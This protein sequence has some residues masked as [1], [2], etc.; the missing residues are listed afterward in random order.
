MTRRQCLYASACIA[1]TAAV[2]TLDCGTLHAQAVPVSAGAVPQ[3]AK[4]AQNA[5]AQ[6]RA[7][8]IEEVV[9]TAQHRSERL[10][11]VPISINAFTRKDIQQ[12]GLTTTSDLSAVTPNLTI[13]L[14]QGQ[15]NQPLIAIRGIGINDE[16]TNNAG[17]VAVYMD[18]VYLSSPSSQTF[19]LF[20]LDRI[21]ILKGPQGT[22]YGRNSSGGAIDYVSAKPTDTLSE[23]FRVDYSSYNTVHTEAALG[24]PI[25]SNLDGRIAVMDDYSDGYVHN[26]LDGRTENG[27]NDYA[28][29]G[30]LLY[31]VN[32]DLKFLLNVH[33]GQLDVTPN[34]YAH[35]GDLEPGTEFTANPVVCSNGQVRA[36]RC[37]DIFGYTQ[38]GNILAAPFPKKRTS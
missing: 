28:A 16:N 18:D 34:D 26:T 6:N 36:D 5:S 7:G 11:N 19:G 27:E 15:G 21:E 13:A 20:D 35:F 24:G 37:V 10:Q 25:T 32:E 1:C 17:P 30:Q 14:S 23:H 33:A 22:I 4:P 38:R 9:V 31:T 12:L 8:A 2:V 29:R 3:P